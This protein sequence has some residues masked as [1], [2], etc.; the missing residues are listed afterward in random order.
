VLGSE[1]SVLSRLSK[2]GKKILQDSGMVVDVDSDFKGIVPELLISPQRDKAALHG[3][4]IQAINQT[5]DAGVRGKVLG[6]YTKEGRRFD[7]R[8]KYPE[9][10]LQDLAFIKSIPISNNRGE[11][12]RLDQVATIEIQDGLLST[13]R[14]DRQRKISLSGNITNKMSQNVV[15]AKLKEAVQ[16]ILP[17]GYIV[18]ESGQ[19]KEFIRTM[20]EF[21]FVFL[22][23]IIVAYIVLASQ[24]NS[25]LDPVIILLALPFS[26]TGAFVALYVTGVSLN[27]YS[28]IGIILLMGIVK[29]NSILLVEFTNQTLNDDPAH[30]VHNALMFACPIRFKPILMTSVTTI[31][32]ALPAAFAFGPGAETKIPLAMTIMGGVIFST[33][34]TLYIVPT[35]YSLLKKKR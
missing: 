15:V 24:Y 5:I 28:L 3:V 9:S 7:V 13:R 34:L 16:K 25:F 1:W 29:K 31:A 21:L 12:I 18:T 14:E 27:I 23:G 32:G 17:E 10:W 4:S 19:S 30:N 35:A 11:T 26:L 6:K 2:E 22:L 20:R 33:V 8:L